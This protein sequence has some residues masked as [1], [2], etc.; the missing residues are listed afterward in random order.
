MSVRGVSETAYVVQ[1]YVPGGVV[2][3]LSN[4][5]LEVSVLRLDFLC[6]DVK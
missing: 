3:R 4:V 1:R 6:F 5:T 2:G